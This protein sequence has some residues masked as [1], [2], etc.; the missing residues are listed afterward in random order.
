M[1]PARSDLLPEMHL[2]T[3]PGFDQDQ[4]FG[5]VLTSVRELSNWVNIAGRY[6][7][8]LSLLKEAPFDRGL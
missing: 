5:C 7:F 4:E 2:L 8:L 3:V 1:V 6:L